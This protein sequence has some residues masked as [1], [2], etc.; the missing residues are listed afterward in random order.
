MNALRICRLAAF[1]LLTAAG[2]L[3]GATSDTTLVYRGGG[4][5]KVVFDGHVHAA[6][7]YVCNDCHTNFNKTGVALFTTQKKGLIDE[8]AHDQG[9]ACFAC[10]N[11]KVAFAVKN[12][13]GCH[14]EVTGF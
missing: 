3:A 2:G 10:H 13:E 12:C 11:G 5:G 9:S 14:R 6:K 1:V 8:A 4:A 7:G